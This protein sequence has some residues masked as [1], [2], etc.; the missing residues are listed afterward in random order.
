MNLQRRDFGLSLLAGA[1]GLAS[2]AAWGQVLAGGNSPSG[3]AAPSGCANPAADFAAARAS[4]PWA[5]G[6]T[7]M[8]TD[9]PP[10]RMQLHGKLPAGLVG[11]FWRNGPARHELGGQRYRHWFDGDGAIQSYDIGPSRHNR[12]SG[13]T[14]RTG[15]THQARFIQTQKFKTETAAGRMLSHTFGTQPLGSTPPRSADEI[16][17]A[18]IH[19][20]SHGG[21]LLALWEGGSATEIDPQTLGTRGLHVLSPETA[22]MPFSAHPRVHRDGTM[23]N[24]GVAN[25][26]SKLIIHRINAAGQLQQT[27]LLPVPHLTMVHDFAVT[28]NHLVF[29]LPP[30]VFE[31]ERLQHGS[32]FLQAHVWRP[33]LGLRVL[34]LPKAQLD[35][36]RW[37]ELPAGMV[38]HIGNA[39]EEG[40]VIRLDCMRAPSAWQAQHG[41]LDTMCGLYAPQDHAQ[42]T[43]LQLNLA[44]GRAS[45]YVAPL[46]AEF[47][48]VDPR[49]MGQPYRQ[50]FALGRAGAAPRPG[51]D[52]V[53]RVNV[54]SGQVDRYVYGD[55][56]LVEEHVFVPHPGRMHAPEGQGWLLGHA[57]DVKRGR[58]VFSVFDA[59]NLAAGPLAQGQMARV[60]PLGLHGSFVAQV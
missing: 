38:F 33:G 41:L 16:N 22:G 55:D 49:F 39:C 52:A 36:P 3:A 59:Q 15:I 7:S 42:L 19:V 58:T 44:N 43:T 56:M 9:A 60:M 47:P 53:L 14:S 51:Y 29:L 35:A 17:V 12:A 24:F 5:V 20:V 8:A 21:K 10:L 50:V 32:S 18:N 1:A 37:F 13:A 26:Q 2:P 31:R 25:F 34:V 57:L 30:L 28:Q 40:G 27:A 48:R 11:A 45:Q 46:V 6:Y 23:W 4:A 54:Q